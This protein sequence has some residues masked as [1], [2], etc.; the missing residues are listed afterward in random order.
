MDTRRV[1][2]LPPVGGIHSLSLSLSRSLSPV[3]LILPMPNHQ[4]DGDADVDAIIYAS[5]LRDIAS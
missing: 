4:D 2:L 5:W 3:P 1:L